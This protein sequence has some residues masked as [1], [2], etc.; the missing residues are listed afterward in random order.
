MI[1]VRSGSIEL[2]GQSIEDVEVRSL[3]K[4]LSVVAQQPRESSSSRFPDSLFPPLTLAF[5]VMLAASIRDNL[6]PDRERN[7]AEIW[8]ALEKIKV[9]LLSCLLGTQ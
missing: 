1:E 2:D 8:V 6:D 4:S 3:R 7:D 5:T 9:R